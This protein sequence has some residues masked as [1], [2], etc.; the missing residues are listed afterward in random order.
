MLREKELAISTDVPLPSHPSGVR[1]ARLSCLSRPMF[2]FA[3]LHRTARVALALFFVAEL[4][5]RGS[6]AA[7]PRLF[8][9][10]GAAAARSDVYA[11]RLGRVLDR[12]RAHRQRR[13]PSARRLSSCSCAP[14]SFAVTLDLSRDCDTDTVEANGGIA[15]TICSIEV[16]DDRGNLLPGGADGTTPLAV[17]SVT[18]IEINSAGAVINV[19]DRHTNVH[20]VTGSSLRLASAADCLDPAV[21]LADQDFPSTGN[22]NCLIDRKKQRFFLLLRLFSFRFSF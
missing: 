8:S 17:T 5:A 7:P 21:A 15:F 6:I 16:M 11:A 3:V 9:G 1:L 20:F 2:P 18:L 19:D 10:T 12:H 14:R 22:C 13:P 4:D